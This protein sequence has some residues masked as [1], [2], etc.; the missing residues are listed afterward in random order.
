MKK[1]TQIL[2]VSLWGLIIAG[3]RIWYLLINRQSVVDTYGFF[4]SA[5]IEAEKGGKPFT[6]GLAHAYTE[7]LSDLLL[8]AGNRIEAVCVYQMILQILWIFFLFAGVS[9]VFGR[10]SGIVSLSILAVLP[11]T[12]ESMINPSTENFYMMH[13]S[14]NLIILG[15]FYLQ[16]QKA[17]WYERRPC[18]LYLVT[19]GFYAGIICIWNYMGFLLTA[20]AGFILVR[21]YFALKE[22]I[23]TQRSEKERNYRDCIMG[24]GRQ[25]FLLFSGMMAGMFATLM[26]YT[27]LTGY[28][29]KEQFTW[30]RVQLESFPGRCQDLS[31]WPVIALPGAVLAGILCQKVFKAAGSGKFDKT[32]ENRASKKEN[33]KRQKDEVFME[34]KQGEYVTTAD[35][36]KIRLLDNPLPTPKKHIQKGMDFDF[37]FDDLMKKDDTKNDRLDF[38]VEISDNDDFDF[39]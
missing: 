3:S 28:T 7:R 20:A 18:E 22:E 34:E 8:F 1:K 19:S 36:R 21:N 30:W 39:T 15:I 38:D 31:T 35:G 37:E 25:G 12:F 14:L 24:T 6:S 17:V 29:I 13:L 23:R 2:L 32:A 33:V 16:A 11:M 27:G 10:I 5:M 4:A 26:K 9:L